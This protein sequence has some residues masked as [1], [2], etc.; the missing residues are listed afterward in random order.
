MK[1]AQFTEGLRV[2]AILSLQKDQAVDGMISMLPVSVERVSH[3]GR[4]ITQ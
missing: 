3:D 1:G 4:R 2:E